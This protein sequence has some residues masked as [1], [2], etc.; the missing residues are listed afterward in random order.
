MKKSVIAAVT[1]GVLMA[2]GIGGWQN[3][4]SDSA[5][6]QNAESPVESLVN[7]IG[8]QAAEELKNVFAQ[9]G[10]DFFK[11]SDL[12]KTLGIDHS[13]QASIEASIKAYI[14]DYD[15]DEGKLEEAKASL[16]TLLGSAEGLTADEIQD[17]IAQI[18]EHEK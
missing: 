15:L 5:S 11:S 8:T 10:S 2:G 18:F 4:S 1:A 3:N 14:R 6:G 16:Q 9:E 13:G 12:E 17:R 7:E